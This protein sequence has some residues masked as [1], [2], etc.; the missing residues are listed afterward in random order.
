MHLKCRS[1]ATD[2][3]IIALLISTLP[4]TA[5]AAATAPAPTDSSA[6]VARDQAALQVQGSHTVRQLTPSPSP[7]PSGYT[8]GDVE[9]AATPLPTGL[10]T[11]WANNARFDQSKS[12]PIES[13]QLFAVGDSVMLASVAE[14]SATFP[15]IWVDVGVSRSFSF[16]IGVT[17]HLEVQGQLRQVLVVG[18]GTNGPIDDADLD[19]LL[20]LANGRPIVIVNAYSDRWWIPEVNQKVQAFAD[21]NRG[22]RLA[23]WAAAIPLIHGGLA[24]DDIHPNPSG[25]VAYAQAV[26]AALDALHEKNEQPKR[27]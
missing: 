26:H 17:E 5:F 27:N 14:L 1:L 22:L 25:G 11:E 12:P 8:A 3:V 4:A 19:R 18:L 2:L 24:G 10:G 7:A 20:R 21:K 6:V 9:A 13:W 23:D 15:E 16:G